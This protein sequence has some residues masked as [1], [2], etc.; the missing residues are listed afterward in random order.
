MTEPSPTVS[1]EKANGTDMSR[2][3]WS[4]GAL[5]TWAGAGLYLALVLAL[6]LVLMQISIPADNRDT[7]MILVGVLSSGVAPA[8]S[9]FVGRRTG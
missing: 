5:R 3:W 2:R 4:D 6:I 9:R 1:D 8:V 7:V